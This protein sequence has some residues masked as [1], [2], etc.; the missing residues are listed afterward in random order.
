MSR[1]DQE[2]LPDIQKWSRDPFRCSEV[3]VRPSRMSESSRETLPDV[4]EAPGCPGVVRTSS[5]TSG[6]GRET[7]PN[8]WE[9]LPDVRV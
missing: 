3:V 6:S 8:V 1:S 9:A 7:L 4:Q 2:T 5:R